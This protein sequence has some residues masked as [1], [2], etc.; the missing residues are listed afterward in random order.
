M[1]Y[2]VQIAGHSEC[3]VCFCLFVHPLSFP[4]PMSSG[5][6]VNVKVF[7][8]L[9]IE[10]TLLKSIRVC[11]LLNIIASLDKGYIIWQEVFDNGAKVRMNHRACR[12]RGQ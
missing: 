10:M 7:W 8:V 3:F 5:H 4:S 2:C 12:E 1:G 6:T 11:S 9:L